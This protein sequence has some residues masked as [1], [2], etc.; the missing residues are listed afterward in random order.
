VGLLAGP[1]AGLRERRQRHEGYRALVGG[2]LRAGLSAERVEAVVSA[3]A[4][5][6]NDEEAAKRFALVADT[7]DKLKGGGR[8]TG[9]PR[10]TT[11]LGDEGGRLVE[12]VRQA[13]GIEGQRL[14]AAYDYR[15][16]AGCPRFQTVRFDPKDFAQRRPSATAGG[17][18]T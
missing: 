6:T 1:W 17:S 16:E 14:I 2:L 15:D 8:V 3:L 13:L 10:L 12:G 18:G 9:W 5:A 7:A 11:L 4:E